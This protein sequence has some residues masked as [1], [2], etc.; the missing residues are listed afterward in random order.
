MTTRHIVCLRSLALLVALVVA[1]TAWGGSGKVETGRGVILFVGDG[2]GVST[3][4]AARIHK[5]ARDRVSPPTSARLAVDRA[6]RSC[7]VRTA[8]LDQ[9]VTDSAASITAMV[10]GA[11]VANRAVSVRRGADGAWQ[12]LTTLVELAEQRGLSTGVVTTTRLTHATPAGLYAHVANRDD[13]LEIAEALVPGGPSS[14]LGDGMEVILGGGRALFLPEASGGRRTDGRDLIA[15]LKR[16]GYVY[17][18]T[19]AEAESARGA[20]KLLGVFADSH[21][22][23]ES[24]RGDDEPSLAAMTALAI[25]MLKRDPRGYFLMV[26]AGR[27]DHAHHVNNGRRAIA[28]TLAMDEAIEVALARSSAR[29]VIYVTSDHDHT[30]V[31]AGYPPSGSDIFAQAGVDEH[32]VPYTAMLYAN[33]PSA[34]LDPPPA[35]SAE[36]LASTDFR[37]RAGVPLRFETHGGMDVPLFVFGPDAAYRDLPAVIDNTD[38]FGLIHSALFDRQE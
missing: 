3:L 8:S 38:V 27:I 19:A 26:E 10:T 6:P 29:D 30:M 15:E 9:M 13:E 1:S 5:G 20:A 22:A 28:D 17:V 36:S 7:L 16:A 12:R 37:E 25:D 31:I 32:G 4:T 21:M 14:A 18:R 35:L 24:D 33:G 34:S 11:K 23:F 2:L